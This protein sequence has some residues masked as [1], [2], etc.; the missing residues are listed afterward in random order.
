MV[1]NPDS[2]MYKH[3]SACIPSYCQDGGGVLLNKKGCYDLPITRTQ[4]QHKVKGKTSKRFID[5]E[6]VDWVEAEEWVV[7][8]WRAGE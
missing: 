1:C 6:M 7:F 3:S 8:K 5:W 4:K 2:Q